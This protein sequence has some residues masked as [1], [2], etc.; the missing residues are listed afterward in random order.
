MKTLKDG[1]IGSYNGYRINGKSYDVSGNEIN[2]KHEVDCFCCRAD[3]LGKMET[4]T[5]LRCECGTDLLYW[6]AKMDDG[7]VRCSNCKRV[8]NPSTGE[9]FSR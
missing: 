4:R 6:G 3:I 2:E 9:L 7:N 1:F 8:Y 5:E